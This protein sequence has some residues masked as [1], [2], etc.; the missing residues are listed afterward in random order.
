MDGKEVV[1]QGLI[2]RI[3]MGEETNVWQMIWLPRDG[4]LRP[5]CCISGDSPD[6][7]SKLIDLLSLTWNLQT[8][9]AY[10]LP[11]DGELIRSI[12]LSSRR[13]QDFWAWH[14]EKIGVFSVRSAY[15]MLITSRERR[16][17]WIEHNPGHSDIVATQTE[18]A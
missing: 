6:T 18:W 16:S 17:D 11:M 5:I 9:E 13:Q 8:V 1:K 10:F 14:Y 12:P 4:L 2:R 15:G 3:G 7:V